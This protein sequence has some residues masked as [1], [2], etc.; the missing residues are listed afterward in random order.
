MSSSG[1]ASSSSDLS[2]NEIYDLEVDDRV[3]A[4][5]KGSNTENDH[6]IF[7]APYEGE[8]LASEGWQESYARELEENEERLN[9][10]RMRLDGSKALDEW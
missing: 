1:S 8:P 10:L 9:N 3:L 4:A 6:A 7:S 2:E 5:S